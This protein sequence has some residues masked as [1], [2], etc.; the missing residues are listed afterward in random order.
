MDTGD[1]LRL[2]DLFS[3]AELGDGVAFRMKSRTGGKL[4]VK[5]QFFT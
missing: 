4:Q 3:V 1:F 2:E 5:A